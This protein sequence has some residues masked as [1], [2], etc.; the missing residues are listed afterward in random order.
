MKPP[1]NH[2]TSIKSP[3]KK[4]TT[5]SIT[6]YFIIN[7]PTSNKQCFKT[8]KLVNKIKCATKTSYANKK[9]HHNFIKIISQFQT[10]KHLPS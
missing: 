7:K 3:N 1:I 4:A 5:N 2:S 10:T 6:K 8:T 9:L